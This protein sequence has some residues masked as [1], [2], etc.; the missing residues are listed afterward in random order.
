MTIKAYQRTATRAE[1]PREL[2]YRAFALVTSRLIAAKDNGRADVVAFVKAIGENRRLWSLLADD[3]AQPGNQLPD[4]VRAQII[5]LALWVSRHGRDVMQG[6]ADI[7]D[8]IEVNRHMMEG[9]A[10]S[11]SGS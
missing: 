9:L 10:A 7:D 6:A 11:P 5:S 4:V 2:E 1:S 3:C 8:L